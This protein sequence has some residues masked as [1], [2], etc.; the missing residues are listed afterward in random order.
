M[1]LKVIGA[2]FGRTATTSLKLA[3]EQLGFN[4]CHHMYEVGGNGQQIDW[5]SRAGRGQPVDWDEVFE[6]F[7]AACDWPSSAYYKELAAHYP[8]AKVV[9]T[10]RDPENWYDSVAN[11]IYPAS[12]NPP[13]WLKLVKPQ[14]WKFFQMTEDTIWQGVFHGEFEDREKSVHIFKTHIDQVK[15]AIPSD[16]LLIHE[17]KDGWEPLCAF[18]GKPIPDTPYPR[19]NEAASLEKLVN[20]MTW[21]RRTPWLVAG[22]V[23]ALFL[24]MISF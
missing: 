18:L 3:L 2:G 20:R 13:L 8:D 16:R 24:G 19:V 14:L 6:N 7:E 15:A 11:T 10:V 22:L 9:L 5:F 21:M 12:A 23:V 4:R 1:P 17:A